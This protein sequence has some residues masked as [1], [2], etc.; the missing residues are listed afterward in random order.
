MFRTKKIAAVS[1]LIGGL[2]VTCAGVAQAHV[3]GGPG[4]CTRDLQGNVTCIQRIEGVIPEDGEIPHQDNC[5]PT[6]PFTVPAALG[7]GTMQIGPKVTCSG[8]TSGAPD[9]ADG[10]MELPGLL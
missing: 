3:V 10:G 9:K 4:N 6:Q 5:L 7:N 2:A 1:G 8:R